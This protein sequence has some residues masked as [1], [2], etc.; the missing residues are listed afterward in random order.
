MD[1][2]G[3]WMIWRR[4]GVIGS[5]FEGIEGEGSGYCVQVLE[6][7]G[8]FEKAARALCILTI[9]GGR[10]AIVYAPMIGC[11]SVLDSH[12]RRALGSFQSSLGGLA[13]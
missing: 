10:D 6:G 13:Q 9:E 11:P 4:E 2:G 1:W 7:G 3:R 5:G 12:P 8:R